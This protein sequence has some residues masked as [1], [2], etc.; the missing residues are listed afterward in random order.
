MVGEKIGEV[1][2]AL[3]VQRVLPS[4]P[5]TPKMEVTQK[6]SG[7]LLG[8]PFQESGTYWS[9]LRPDGT[10]YGE[11]N[12]V[13]MGDG[14]ALATWVGQGTGTIAADSS[15]EYRGAIYLYSTSDAWKRLNS[16][17]TLF[18]YRVDA[19]GNYNAEFWEWK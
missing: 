12:G 11:G 4:E 1:S 9:K 16:V 13:Y 7:T 5:G 15:V 17:A 10:L 3:V 19:D 6:G 14:G 18:E 8:V 2:G